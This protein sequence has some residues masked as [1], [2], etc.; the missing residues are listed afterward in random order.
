M[1]NSKVSSLFGI[2]KSDAKNDVTGFLRKFPNSSFHY[3][4]NDGITVLVTQEFPGADIMRV[5]TAI[6]S[7]DEVKFRKSVGK[8]IAVY[9]MVNGSFINV[10]TRMIYDFLL[11]IGIEH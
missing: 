3:N 8:Y 7:M 1:S 10:P 9:N 4:E 5:S 6:M 2:T 11:A